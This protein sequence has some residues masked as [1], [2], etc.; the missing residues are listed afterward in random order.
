VLRESAFVP[1]R[2][3]RAWFGSALRK[4][5]WPGRWIDATGNGEAILMSG[6]AT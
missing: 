6:R 3:T 5:R 4:D 1:R 2:V